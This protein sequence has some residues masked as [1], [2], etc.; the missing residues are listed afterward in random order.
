M[1]LMLAVAELLRKNGE[2]SKPAGQRAKQLVIAFA[3][4]SAIALT[5]LWAS[6]GFRYVARGEGLQL[7]PPLAQ[8]VHYLSRPRE[9]RLL[10]TMARYRLLPES[11]IFGLA[12][13][14]IKSDF[15]TSY[16]FGQIY[17]HGIWY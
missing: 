16:L 3:V 1:L 8:S 12:D 7:N 17:P 15:Y 10:E 4:I 13:V 11:Y 9:T 5:T 6:Y 14:R 2:G